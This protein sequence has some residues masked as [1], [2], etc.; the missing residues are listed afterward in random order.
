MPD[1]FHQLDAEAGRSI[2]PAMRPQLGRGEVDFLLTGK[3]RLVAMVVRP[4]P[5]GLGFPPARPGAPRQS[6]RVQTLPVQSGWLVKASLTDWRPGC[7]ISGRI[8]KKG[9]KGS[10]ASG[11]AGWII[12]QNVD[13]V[14]LFA[15][16]RIHNV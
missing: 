3:T 12:E 15:P 6:D 11:G 14:Q 1:A 9:G 16:P 4:L 7:T 2:S 5:S 13:F 8:T 10:A